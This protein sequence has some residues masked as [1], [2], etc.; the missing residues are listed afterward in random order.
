MVGGAPVTARWA[1]KIGA[2]AYGNDANECV[3]IAMQLMEGK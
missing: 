3:K 2:D 1:R